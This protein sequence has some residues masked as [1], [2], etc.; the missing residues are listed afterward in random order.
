MDKYI[1]TNRSLN[2]REKVK[3][4]VSSSKKKISDF[5]EVVNDGG[6]EF[7]VYIYDTQEE[8]VFG[9]RDRGFGEDP[10]HMCACSKDSDHSLNFFEPKDEPSE[11]EWDKESY[12]RQNVIFHEVVHGMQNYIYGVQP[13]WLT[14][15]VAKYLDGT[16]SKGVDYLLE[17]YINKC[18]VPEMSELV[19]EFGWHQ[20]KY[21]AYDYAYLIVSYLIEKDGKTNFVNN[22]YDSNY[23]KELEKNDIIHTAVK[24]Y[25]DKYGSN[26]GD[27]NDESS[28]KF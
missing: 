1:C 25:N 14:E 3:D 16:Y 15:G 6:F 28:V 12:F 7:S 13:E 27:M 24:Y 26:K 19:N 18:D 4:I 10:P 11:N 2:F 21:D 23:L 9:L 17:N 20:D 5:F 8:L 22:I